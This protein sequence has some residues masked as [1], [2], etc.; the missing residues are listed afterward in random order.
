MFQRKNEKL[1]IPS[2]YILLFLTVICIL[3]MVVTFTTEYTNL[4]IKSPFGA[5]VIPFQ[6]GVTTV[7]NWFGD[8]SD[9]L[10]QIRA[11]LDEN[12]ALKQEIA[13]L[14]VENDLLQQDKYEL[15]SLRQLYYLDDQYSEYEKVGARIIARDP[16]NWFHS[17]MIDKGLEDGLSIDM[18]V[19]ADGGLVGRITEIGMN[20][21]KVVSI[22]DDNNYVSGMILS[23]ADN[24]IV[25]GDL[26]LVQ[27]GNIKFSQLIDSENRVTVGDKIVTSNISDKYLPGIS[28]GYITDIY[29][30]A[31]NLTKSGTVSPVVDFEHIKEVLVI[32]QL[33]Q[34]VE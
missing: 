14:K 8:R 32:L 33:K 6:K 29:K 24:L 15:T 21:S 13:E 2:K 26:E 9:E 16:G 25:E 22:I 30:D 4:L 12:I 17:F 20:W 19:I 11:L 7:G 27:V 23:T 31:N 3:F 28:I 5:I 10:G 34:M 1:N 18:N